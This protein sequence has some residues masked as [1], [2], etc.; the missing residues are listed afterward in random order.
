MAFACV[1][2]SACASISAAIKIG[3]ED[4]SANITTSLG[5]AMVSI[6]TKPDTS[7]LAVATYIFPGPTILSTL[8][9]V[10]VPNVKAAMPCAPPI[11]K[12][13]LIFN[14]SAATKIEGA[15]LPFSFGG[16]IKTMSLTPAMMAGMADMST[17]EG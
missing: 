17:V 14:I 15:M 2:C 3:F 1:S 10:C 11:L 12:I 6:P 5:P 9:I 4:S 8:G 7:F 16:E 13:F